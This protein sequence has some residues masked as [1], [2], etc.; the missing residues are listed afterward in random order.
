MFRQSFRSV[1][2]IL[3]A[4]LLAVAAVV[5]TGAV[6]PTI[7]NYW[8]EKERLPRPDLSSVAR[9]RFL[10]TLDFPPFSYLDSQNRLTGFHVE[11]ARAICRELD[12]L[13]R[14]QIQAL[15]WEELDTALEKGEGEALIAGT[16]INA[17]TRERYIFTR[18]HLRFPA[19]FVVPEGKPLAEPLHRG[20]ANK[21]IGVLASSAHE[22]MLRSYFPAARPVTFARPEW[23]MEALRKGTIDGVFGDGMRLSF[24][25]AGSGAAGCCRFAGG[26]YLAP[27]FLGAGLAI[28]VRH[29]N[30][31]LV[32]AFDHALREIAA[33]GTFAELYLKYFPVSFY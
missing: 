11:L 6:G 20:V 18:P 33:K 2:R 27:E 5:P 29:E 14:C 1:L 9:I 24:W 21:R 25:L 30:E 26:T 31:L 12:I 22:A 17:E 15:P 4:C 10:T 7:P 3:L 32:Q 13:P 23:M 19:R 28:A 16:P 8:D